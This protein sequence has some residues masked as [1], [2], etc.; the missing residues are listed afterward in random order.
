MQEPVEAFPNQPTITALTAV[1]GPWQYGTG[2][3][4]VT[5]AEGGTAGGR[6]ASTVRWPL[7]PDE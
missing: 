2:L 1:G 7:Q 5:I 3:A 4:V 6:S